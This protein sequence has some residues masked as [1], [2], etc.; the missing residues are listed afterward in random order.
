[1]T[2]NQKNQK[3]QYLESEVLYLSLLISYEII[4]KGFSYNVEA[5]QSY[6]QYTINELKLLKGYAMPLV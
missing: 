5:M 2:D 3:I 4:N 6:L 1:M